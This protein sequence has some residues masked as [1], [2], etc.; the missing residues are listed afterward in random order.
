MKNEDVVQQELLLLLV[1]EYFLYS[2][3]IGTFKMSELFSLVKLRHKRTTV[4]YLFVYQSP[5]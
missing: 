5:S 4:Y 3:H 2:K 1:R